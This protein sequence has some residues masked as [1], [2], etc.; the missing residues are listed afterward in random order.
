MIMRTVVTLLIAAVTLPA[1]PPAT[2]AAKGTAPMPTPASSAK[3]SGH[4]EIKGVNYYYELR[5]KG[6]PLLLLHGG[7]GSIDMFGPNLPILAEHRQVIA[8]D[9]QGHGRTT[10]GDR[11]ISLIDMGDDMAAIVAKLGHEHV[12]VLGYSMGGAWRSGSP[13]SI[14]PSFAGSCWSRQASRRTASIRK[15]CRCRRRWAPRWPSR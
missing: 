15:C 13:S 1:V 11:P 9:L 10:L 4:V 12:D 6:E 2:H 8:V 5:G 14:R 7:L 3:S